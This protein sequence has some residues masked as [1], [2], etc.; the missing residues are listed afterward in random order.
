MRELIRAEERLMF[1]RHS[2]P[3]RLQKEAAVD[4]ARQNE[5]ESF[6]PPVRLPWCRKELY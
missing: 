4:A 3:Q 5:P 2:E 6:E 1:A